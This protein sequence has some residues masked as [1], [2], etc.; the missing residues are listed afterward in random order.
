MIFLFALTLF[1][2][3]FLAFLV[4]PMAARMILPTFGGSPAV[5]NTAMVFFQTLLLLGYLYA[6]VL[7][8]RL[9]LRRHALLHAGLLLLAFISLPFGMDADW[10]PPGEDHPLPWLLGLLATMVGLPFFA[11]LSGT[12]LLQRWFSHLSP[13]VG[14][15]PYFLYAASNF[16]SLLGLLAYPL[17]LEP[18][19]TLSQQSWVWFGGYG[20]LV[21]LVAGIA[22]KVHRSADTTPAAT[23]PVPA[24]APGSVPQAAPAR[25]SGW[26]RLRW[27][28]LAMVPS[29]LM[30]G[31]TMHISS[32]LASVPLFWVIPLA[33]YLV[34]YILAFSR[35]PEAL[36]QA[37]KVLLPAAI[38]LLAFALRYEL[39]KLFVREAIQV[40]LAAFFAAAMVCHG[41]LARSRPDPRYL[42]EFYLLLSLGGMLGGL[43]NALAAPLLFD[44][45]VE[46]PWVILLAC[47][48]APRWQ[49]SPPADPPSTK[50]KGAASVKS[51]AK[52]AA[53]PPKPALPLPLG[54]VALVVFGLSMA[55][56]WMLY[57]PGGR[58]YPVLYRERSFYGVH[59]VAYVQEGNF[60]ELLHGSTIHGRQRRDRRSEPL[61]YFN[62]EGPLG[63]AFA[64]FEQLPPKNDIAVIGLGTGTVA[65]Y[66]RAGQ[67]LTFYEIDPVVVKIARDRRFF[68]FLSDAEAR[69]VHLHI[70]I[71]DA[72]LRLR[73]AA[74]AA[75]DLLIVDAFSSDS[76]PTHLLTREAL[77]LYLDKLR[78][79]GVL[80]F[81]IS[82]FNLE[83]APVLADLAAE[84]KLAA[85]HQ[86]DRTPD[87]DG[88]TGSHWVVLAQRIEDL[89]G[90]A[91]DARWPRL[92]PRHP[93]IIWTDQFS[94]LLSVLRKPE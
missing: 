33:I 35:L 64:A 52:G 13:A 43:F 51:R 56:Y 54:S 36:H 76:I 91:A 80:V 10:E 69:G 15:D 67:R 49:R 22:W 25:P 23:A 77:A 65:C 72:R 9:G 24:K 17:A 16:G 4:Q 53:P 32:D 28:A 79:G 75:Y 18:W 41:E 78:P 58:P 5:W 60:N 93:P 7:P 26:Q 57:P 59:L 45:V 46:Y 34:T 21:V 47:F 1:V 14:R 62:R 74:D 50:A 3:G 6:H 44:R 27:L 82:N 89:G 70:V 31:V 85:R 29:S 66:L 73:R 86:L 63:Q 8:L 88:K 38:L 2:S 55:G 37:M 84:R 94:N 40:H 87:V 30:L 12:P 81:H 20:V 39:D 11:V 71:G 83:L 42:T 48:L 61:A 90:I 92:E 68:T 19:L